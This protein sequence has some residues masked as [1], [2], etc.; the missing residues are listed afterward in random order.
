[1]FHHIDIGTITTNI[2]EWRPCLVSCQRFLHVGCSYTLS[3]ETNVWTARI[4]C[5]LAEKYPYS[6]WHCGHRSEVS[7]SNFATST[8]CWLVD[9]VLHKQEATFIFHHFFFESKV[10]LLTFPIGMRERKTKNTRAVHAGLYCSL[11]VNADS[12][13]SRQQ[14]PSSKDE[15][16]WR[17]NG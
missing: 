9:H 13:I 14:Q 16:I 6:I 3:S 15:K 2:C 1:M 5:F 17:M 12:S 11:V 8:C 7:F 10:I 4:S